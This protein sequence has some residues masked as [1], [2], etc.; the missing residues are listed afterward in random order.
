MSDM[1][2]ER[3][4]VRLNEDE[5]SLL[6]SYSQQENKTESEIVRAALEIYFKEVLS[7]RSCYELACTLKIIGVTK[8]LPSDLSF[9]KDYLKGFGE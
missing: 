3:I 1:K 7:Q 6:H 5:Y 2:E 8:K 4:T 9:N